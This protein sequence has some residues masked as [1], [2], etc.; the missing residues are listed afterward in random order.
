MQLTNQKPVTNILKLNLD[1]VGTLKLVNDF[2]SM[3]HEHVLR[4]L[5]LEDNGLVTVKLSDR[6]ETTICLPNL[7]ET[8]GSLG[9]SHTTDFQPDLCENAM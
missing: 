1:I 6:M 8:T 4:G 9:N 7:A 3:P 2:A 5:Y